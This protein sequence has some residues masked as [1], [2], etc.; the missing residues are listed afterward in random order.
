[1]TNETSQKIINSWPSTKEQFLTWFE[2]NGPGILHG[3]KI[4]CLMFSGFIILSIIITLIKSK[5]Y[6]KESLFSS[7]KGADMP[8]EKPNILK[9]EWSNQVQDKLKTQDIEQAKMALI[10]ADALLS[11]VLTK[12]GYRGETMAD[13]LKQIDDGE[14]SN[15][16]ALWDAHKLRNQIAHEPNKKFRFVQ[17]QQ[18]I[19]AI[20]SALKELQGL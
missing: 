8:K 13:Q 19:E 10:K 11:N 5:P 4:F 3:F 9:Q 16:Q 15:A 18:S 1:M 2:N 7:L 6:L 12:A 14:I 17:I 20:E